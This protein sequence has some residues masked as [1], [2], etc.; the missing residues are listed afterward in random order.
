METLRLKLPKGFSVCGPKA[1][2]LGSE[3]WILSE[4]GHQRSEVG[5]GRK[6]SRKKEAGRSPY[7]LPRLPFTPPQCAPSLQGAPA[8]EPWRVPEL[9]GQRR[10]QGWGAGDSLLRG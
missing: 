9:Q 5:R 4:V 7:H 10:R 6:R 3:A 2:L 1:S 8:S